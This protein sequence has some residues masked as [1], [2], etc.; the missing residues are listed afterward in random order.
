MRLAAL[1][2]GGKDS[3]Y[4]IYRARQM[5]HTVECLVTMRPASDDSLLFHYPNSWVTQYQ[6][7]AMGISLVTAQVA[8]GSSRDGEAAALEQALAEAKRRFPGIG[9]VVSGGI[10]SA[11]QKKAFEG[12]CRRLGGLEPMAPLWGVDPEKYMASLLDDKFEVIVVGV[13]A[14][15]LGKEWLGRTIGREALAALAKLSKKYGFNLAFEGGEAETLVVDCP[16]FSSKRLEIKEAQVRWDG[17]RGAYEISQV[18]LA[19]K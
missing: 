11:F 3:A 2:S 10:S 16:L 15:G 7:Q 8:P 14:M 9:G 19:D 12:V 1:F 13:S 4:S 5:G 6:A 17:Q 18:S